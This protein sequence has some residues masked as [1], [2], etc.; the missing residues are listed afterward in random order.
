MKRTLE[1]ALAESLARMEQGAG[2]EECLRGREEIAAEL[3]PLLEAAQTVR[4]ERARVPAHDPR[5]FERGRRR[6]HAERARRSEAPTTAWSFLS[7]RPLLLGGV[8]AAA[9]LAA[10]LGFTTGLFEFDP[11]TTSAHMEGVVGRVDEDALVLVT[12]DGEVIIRI[13]EDTIVLDASGKVTSGGAL[14]PGGVVK[15][16]VEREDGSFAG[17]KIEIEDDDDDRGVGAE[18]E[19]T[20][21]I[22]SMS[23]SML[24]VR[25]SFGEAT[26]RIGPETEVKDP[27]SPGRT[28]KVHATLQEDGSYLAR[29][30]E[31]AGGDDDDDG[32]DR[33][34]RDGGD[35]DDDSDS[36]GPGPAT[37]E[38]DDDDDE[39]SD[40]SGPGS[41]SSGSGSSGSGSGDD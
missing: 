8:A 14:V 30:I 1:E 36:S 25:A 2:V 41:S 26:V 5:A 6:M 22:R 37:S 28:V 10:L 12:D 29:E 11:G 18:V 40:N 24:S 23:G 38:P 13:G 20:G 32:D 19:F 34:G 17:L 35:D 15:V 39:K 21:V 31:S 9:A 16:E 7:A 3:R 33:S 4:S 27:L